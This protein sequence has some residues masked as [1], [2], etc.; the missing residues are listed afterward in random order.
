MHWDSLFGKKGGII[1][2]QFEEGKAICDTCKNLISQIMYK[3]DK[4]RFAEFQL[5]S[6]RT[7]NVQPVRLVTP[8]D[9]R[10]SGVHLMFQS[11]LRAKSLVQILPSASKFVAHYSPF[12]IDP[13]TWLI[14]AEFEAITKFTHELSM[15]LQHDDPGELAFSWMECYLCYSQFKTKESS[16]YRVCDVTKTWLPNTSIDLLP[17]VTMV[18]DDFTEVGRKFI[19]RL[20]SEMERYFPHPDTDQIIAVLLHPYFQYR[21]QEYVVLQMTILC[22]STAK[23]CFLPFDSILQGMGDINLSE[24]SKTK[25]MTKILM[26]FLMKLHEDRVADVNTSESTEHNGGHE[27]SDS[28]LNSD[29]E[30]VFLMEGA[31]NEDNVF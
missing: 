20:C 15:L 10:V 21:G 19:D 24:T 9:T 8:N 23:P 27:D 22:V 4:S 14:I 13:D 1:V 26:S 3:K 30:D 11:L 29:V 16:G 25:E 18:Y 17:R 6:E 2:D 12:I 5:I 7:Y 28:E 31:N